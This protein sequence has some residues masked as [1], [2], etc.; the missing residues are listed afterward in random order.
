VPGQNQGEKPDAFVPSVLPPLVVFFLSLSSDLAH[1][2]RPGSARASSSREPFGGLGVAAR[3]KKTQRQEKSSR[4]RARGEEVK[5]HQKQRK[6]PTWPNKVLSGKV[7]RKGEEEE[8]LKRSG[9]SRR[10]KK[11]E[12]EVKVNPL[13]HEKENP[14]PFR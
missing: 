3:E 14:T 2:H 9:I 10:G 5:G 8:D 6:N 13:L 7:G 4:R 11:R 12:V 1:I